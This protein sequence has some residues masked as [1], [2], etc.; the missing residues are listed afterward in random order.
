VVVTEYLPHFAYPVVE[1]RTLCGQPWES[2]ILR[3]NPKADCE[4]CVNAWV[5]RTGWSF[6]LPEVVS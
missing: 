4:A 5:R 6:P 1:G 2:I 3:S